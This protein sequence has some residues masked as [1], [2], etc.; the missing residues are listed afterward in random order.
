M[1]G[2]DHRPPALAGFTL[3]ELMVVIVLLGILSAMILPEMRGTYGDAVLRAASRD[4]VNV[5]ALASSRAVSFNQLH[6]VRLDPATGRFRV[7][8][9]SRSAAGETVFMPVRDVAG[10]EGQLDSRL[11]VRIRAGGESPDL[12]TD[13]GEAPRNSGHAAMDSE[14]VPAEAVSFYPDGTADRAEIVLR[15][16]DGYGL[17][18]RL[19]PIT[20]RLR[21]VELSRR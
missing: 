6:R 3:V 2:R 18:L 21:A 10:V 9:K 8:K 1:S 20:A 7:E 19:N 5:C 4:L 15:D 11:V 12:P 17:A 14:A 13:R 16:R